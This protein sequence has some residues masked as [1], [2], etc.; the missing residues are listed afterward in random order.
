[1][2]TRTTT[3]ARARLIAAAVLVLTASAALTGCDDGEGVRDEGP[4]S[5]SSQSLREP[6]CAPAPQP[7]DGP[8]QR[9]FCAASTAQ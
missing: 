8:A 7:A 4:S 5:A 2:S 1:M 9:S 3:T 6:A